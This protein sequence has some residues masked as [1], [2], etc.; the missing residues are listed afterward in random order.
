MCI[1]D[2]AYPLVDEEVLRFCR[3]KRAV[4][5]VEEGQPDFHEQAV[6]A[7]LRRAGVDTTL[8]G[9]DML[10][11]GG[12]Y[13]VAVLRKGLSTFLERHRPSALAPAVPVTMSVRTA[14]PVGA[15][16]SLDPAVLDTVLPPRLPGLCVGCPERPVFSSLK[17]VE[18]ELGPHH[19]A[20]DI[21]CH[22][23]S[24]LPPFNIGATT[25]GYGLGVAL[26]LIHISEPTRPY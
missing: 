25:M 16:A 1:R 8:H 18:C 17:L 20:A 7:I 9:K 15:K 4:L 13:T 11:M 6:H 23:F 21:G 14:G 5:L 22:L 19:V 3:G 24:I 12:D 10:P 2:R 26:S